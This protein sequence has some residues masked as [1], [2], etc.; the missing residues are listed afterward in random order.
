[1]TD[2]TD[3]FRP[4]PLA[5]SFQPANLVFNTLAI[6]PPKPPSPKLDDTHL[7]VPAIY[8]KKQDEDALRK[9]QN[10]DVEEED[11]DGGKL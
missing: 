5:V 8:K 11:D 1:M 6:K 3:A 9:Q 10:V 7:K 4:S 2:G